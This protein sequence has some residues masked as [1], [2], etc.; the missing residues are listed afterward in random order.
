V[1][2]K[3]FRKI[4]K[5]RKEISTLLGIDFELV[6]DKFLFGSFQ[7][8]TLGAD[9]KTP[10]WQKN[11]ELLIEILSL[12]PKK[13]R[14]LLILTG[15]RR[16]YIINEC[17]KRGI[18]YYY[19]GR[20]PAPGVDDIGINTL[21]HERMALFY[22]LIDCYLVTSKSEGGP[23]AILEASFCNTLIFS[24]DV[25]LAPD[26]LDSRCIYNTIDRVTSSLLHAM[27]SNN[28]DYINNLITSNFNNANS[29]CSYEIMKK[30]WKQIYESI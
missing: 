7:R 9:L 22:N 12:L 24:T 8:D 25:G 14:W 18:P 20:K 2:E 19:Y 28:Q 15:P 4:D 29:I 6:K 30:R 26:I 3:V 10:K 23:K 21:D 27:R 17:E 13:N 1:D 16:H 11:P 5:S